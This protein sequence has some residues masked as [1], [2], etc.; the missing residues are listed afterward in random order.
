[1][2]DLF[3]D[4]PLN[5]TDS[6]D[7][8]RKEEHAEYLDERKDGFPDGKK[9]KE[10]RKGELQR[11]RSAKQRKKKPFGI[12]KTVGGPALGTKAQKRRKYRL[13]PEAKLFYIRLGILAGV[14]CAV[15]LALRLTVF[16]STFSL[17]YDAA[18]PFEFSE[19]L[20][21]QV[22]PKKTDDLIVMDVEIT[23]NASA[24][25]ESIRMKFAELISEQKY[26]SWE[27]EVRGSKARLHKGK[28]SGENY[29]TQRSRF[30]PLGTTLEALGRIPLEQIGVNLPIA[31]KTQRYVFSTKMYNPNI[32]SPL[33]T[34]R[35]V[36]ASAKLMLVATGGEIS[37]VDADWKPITDYMTVDC[38]VVTTEKKE[39]VSSLKYIILLAVRLV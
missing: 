37:P 36:D 21:N 10:K 3:L 25:I 27:L 38:S 23:V 31:E 14:L 32:N 1:M 12:K 29:T 28:K 17:E 20:I 7:P 35:A 39:T 13:K 11:K 8:Q 15:V 30:P 26:R 6:V 34:Q 4:D 22:R 19:E 24:Q 5:E 9:E 18:R 16:K 2:D 33:F